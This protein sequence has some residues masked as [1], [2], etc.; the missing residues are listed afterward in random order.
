MPYKVIDPRDARAYTCAIL[1]LVDEGVLER[2]QLI[3]DLLGWMSEA[4]VRAFCDKNFRDEDNFCLIGAADD[5]E[6]KVE[7]R[8]F[9]MKDHY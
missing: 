1:E 9:L 7:R 5:E 2:D 6:D 3:Q 8:L 4:D